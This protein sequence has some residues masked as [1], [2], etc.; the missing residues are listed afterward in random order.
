[1]VRGV[2]CPVIETTDKVI[3][4]RRLETLR[5][6]AALRRAETVKGACQ[7]AVAVLARNRRDVP[8]ASLYLLSEDSQSVSLIA[9]TNGSPQDEANVPL[10]QSVEWPLADALANP[11]VL[12]NLADGRLPAGDWSQAP[13]QTYLAPIILPGSQRARAILVVGLNPHKRLDESYRSFLELLVSQV[14]STIADTLAYEA[15]RGRA[16]AL[17]EIDRAKTRFFSNVSHEFRTPRDRLDV[18]HRN[19]LRLLKLVNSMLDFSRIEAGR[20]KAVFEPLDLP[21]LTADLTSNFRSAFERAGLQLIVKCR[22]LPAPVY[23]DRDMWEKIVLNLLSNAFKFTF[24]GKVEVTL[25]AQDDRVA[26]TVR[27]TGVGVPEAELPHLFERFHRIEGQRSRTYEGSGIGLALVQE[28]VKLLGGD[29]AVESAAGKGACFTVRIPFGESHPA[30]EAIGPDKALASTSVRA[31]AFVEEALRWLPGDSALPSAASLAVEPAAGA[32]PSTGARVPRRR[33]QCGHAGLHPKA[34]G[35]ALGCRD[36]RRRRRSVEGHVVAATRSR[37]GGHHDAGPGRVGSA[38]GRSRRSGAAR[39][40]GDPPVG[41]RRRGEPDP[42]LAGRRRRLSRQALL[43]PRA[44]RS[45][46]RAFGV[47]PNPERLPGGGPRE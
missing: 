19:S 16:E 8:F 46:G 21:T 31:E 10:A 29:I 4:A 44:H 15:E 7:Q 17:A 27:D 43:G 36:S 35:S 45:C 34:A 3:G 33:R 24:E 25:S 1:V 2:F 5:E 26:L 38:A 47:E 13:E 40:P 20:A 39:S 42:G 32:S 23:V 22:P 18:A 9:A 28:L 11:A 30:R 14:A 12:D 6:L 37:S 41:A